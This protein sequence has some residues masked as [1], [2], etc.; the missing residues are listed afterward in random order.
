[1]LSSGTGIDSTGFIDVLDNIF[2]SEELEWEDDNWWFGK[3]ADDD[4]EG[5]KANFIFLN[6]DISVHRFV[7]FEID[8]TTNTNG[9][10]EWGRVFTGPVW[11]FNI[12]RQYGAEIG[13]ESRTLVDKSLAG[14]QFFDI[15]DGIRTSV[16][17]LEFM[18]DDEAFSQAFELT[19][20]KD[21]HGD[22][23]W[24]PRFDNKV[25]LF[26]EAFWGR[27]RKLNKLELAAFNING[28][29]FEVE[30]RQ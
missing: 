19:R 13:F 28:M 25:T 15:R 24:V 1:M 11:E 14:V 12:S 9:F 8:N 6:E 21:V 27:L 26:R 4:R 2:A 18:S 10:I 7:R 30:E 29:G 5:I 3:L 16:F 17:T 20:R 23:L 22:I